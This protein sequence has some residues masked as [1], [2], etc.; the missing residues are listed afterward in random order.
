SSSSMLGQIEGSLIGIR[1]VKGTTA[2]RFERRRYTRIMDR[3][4]G[5]QLHMAFIDAFSTPIMEMLNLAI[6]GVVTVFSA[7][8]VLVRHSPERGQFVLVIACLIA[9]ADSLRR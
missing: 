6:F 4:L 8:L 3:L 1:V 2:E 7:Y 5:E 9:I